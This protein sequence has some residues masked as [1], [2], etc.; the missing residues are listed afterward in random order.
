M[1]D[2]KRFIG[3]VFLGVVVFSLFL[4]FENPFADDKKV[5]WA[6]KT[7]G[8]ESAD[9]MKENVNIIVKGEKLSEGENIVLDSEVT[10]EPA[11]GYTKSSFKISEVI[12]NSEDDRAISVGNTINISEAEF[13]AKNS[14]TT[15]TINDYENMKQ[16]EDYVLYL[17]VADEGLYITA[18]VTFGKIPINDDETELEESDA[19]EQVNEV[20]NEAQQEFAE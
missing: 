12:K 20:I 15:Y 13:Y 4:I 14:K 10:N 7:D 2:E 3:I 11:G 6:G 19:N 17:K 5:S 18:G 16:G 8:H 9:A 1:E